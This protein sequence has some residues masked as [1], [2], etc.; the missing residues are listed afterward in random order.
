MGLV[1]GMPVL[2]SVV[3][4]ARWMRSLRATGTGEPGAWKVG[5]P[6]SHHELRARV[7]N[8]PPLRPTRVRCERG[9]VHVVLPRLLL[10]SNRRQT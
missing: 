2:A 1:S 9:S 6:L 3:S 4:T 10:K 8:W 7:S 5:R